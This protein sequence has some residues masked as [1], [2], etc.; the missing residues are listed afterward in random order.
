MHNGQP[1]SAYFDEIPAN[2]FPILRGENWEFTRACPILERAVF[3][4][5]WSLA[6]NDNVALMCVFLFPMHPAC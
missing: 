1:G 6:R 2:P 4:C 3:L 5:E